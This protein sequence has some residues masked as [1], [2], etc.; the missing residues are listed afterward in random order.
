MT[1]VPVDD[2]ELAGVDVVEAVEVDGDVVPADLG[3]V[4]A[5]EAVDAA[6]A[7]EEPLGDLGAPFVHPEIAF[8]G[9][10]G[11]R[12]RFHDA[13]GGGDLGAHAAIAARGAGF[14]VDLGRETNGAA[15]T[16]AGVSLGRVFLAT[17]LGLRFHVASSF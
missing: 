15:V 11:K 10:Q 6:G 9:Q 3:Q 16:A 12:A 7:T 17:F 2:G 1:A 4:A 5:A 14:H 13:G 8:P